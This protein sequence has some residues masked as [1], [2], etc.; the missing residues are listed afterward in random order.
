[1]LVAVGS[2]LGTPLEAQ[3]LP[4][5]PQAF[6][7]GL[8]QKTPIQRTV[9]EA[10]LENGK[11]VKRLAKRTFTADLQKLSETYVGGDWNKTGDLAS[12]LIARVNEACTPPA[13]G[14]ET[15]DQTTGR[16]TSGPKK[17]PI[18]ITRDYVHLVWV[19]RVPAA[20]DDSVFSMLVH[21][22]ALPPYSRVLPG[23]KGGKAPRLFEVFVSD[24]PN[25]ELSSHY[26]SKPLPDP[27]LDQV[28]QVVEKFLGPMFT[29]FD[30]LDPFSNQM[31]NTFMVTTP[32]VEVR[33]VAR[34]VDLPEARAGVEI[35]LRVTE[36]VT[37]RTLLDGTG[38]L[39]GELGAQG[40]ADGDLQ[41]VMVDAI[42]A[43]P[44]AVK[45]TPACRTKGGSAQACKDALHAAVTGPILGARAKFPA[46]P[47]RRDLDRLE[48]ALRAFVDGL[49]PAVIAGKAS[50]DNSPLTHF[51]FGL[52]TSYA[53]GVSGKDLRAN[54]TDGKVVN[55]PLPQVLNMVVLNIDAMGYQSKSER[56]WLPDAF[57]QPFVGVV[58][59]P[60]LGVS[61]G[62]S[63]R[64]LSNLGVNM[65][66]AQLFITR[67]ENG[68]DFGAV[69]DEKVT[70]ANGNETFRYSEDLRRD[71]LQRGQLH[72]FFV[73]VSYNFK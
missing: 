13:T 37:G 56:R 64:V 25:A 70:D 2:C 54:V 12:D 7:D 43:I 30:R 4:A 65:G 31:L 50:L 48:A 66:Y 5:T 39:A 59:S 42:A 58:F 19:G 35:A 52:L 36:P 14:D 44:E 34:T 16:T 57:L 10:V 60:D 49:K 29:L 28:P 6:C 45:N 71:P 40:L 15:P 27:L 46:D 11:A 23:L 17:P 53:V 9:E 72:A 68:L 67:P 62:L 3:E 63:F 33:F 47:G 61:A 8:F 24:N 21:E 73:G 32:P 26:V 51:T 1:M 20:A 22:P 55:A 41:Q 38:K 69:L 18:D